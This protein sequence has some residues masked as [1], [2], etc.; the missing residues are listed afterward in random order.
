MR[1]Q[2]AYYGGVIGLV[3]FENSFAV[4]GR[5][6]LTGQ[7]AALGRPT[8]RGSRVPA[9]TTEACAQNWARLSWCG[10]TG[11]DLLRRRP[12]EE[13]TRSYRPCSPR[14]RSPSLD[15]LS[16]R[17]RSGGHMS[18]RNGGCRHFHLSTRCI[19][20]GCT[21]DGDVVLFESSQRHMAGT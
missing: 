21:L 19:R 16:S 4:H 7:C 10:P 14:I 11:R 2:C 8:K 18:G 12:L 1:T 3:W 20:S 5:T 6:P 15:A 13:K 17:H 9:T